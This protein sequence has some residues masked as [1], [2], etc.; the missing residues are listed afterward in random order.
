MG[1]RHPLGCMGGAAG[2]FRHC[3]Q[4]CCSV[5]QS[6]STLCD[7]MHCRTPSFPALQ[8]LLE[9]AL[10]HVHWLVMPSNHV[11]PFSSCLRSFP[12]SGSY[13]MSQFFAWWPK[14][15]CFTFSISPSSEYSGL[16]SYR[17]DW[18]DLLAIQ[19]TLKSLLQ[20]HSSKASILWCS[21]FFIVQVSHPSMTTGSQMDL[22]Y[23]QIPQLNNCVTRGKLL[24]LF[25]SLF[26][27]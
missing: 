13:P 4:P 9:F 17:M 7:P 26:S 21:A 19:G 8:H 18:F 11:I 24:Y 25:G 10:T 12:A 3:W 1:W 2:S 5:A 23:F 6:C 27:H 14:Y 20:Y 22:V 16:I 15:W